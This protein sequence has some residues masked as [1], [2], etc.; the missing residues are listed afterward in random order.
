VIGVLWYCDFE[1]R[2]AYTTRGGVLN[3]DSR[4]SLWDRPKVNECT[5]ASKKSEI[6]RR[7]RQGCAPL[8]LAAPTSHFFFA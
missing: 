8:H 4:V 3:T 5:K 6:V 2:L 1:K 7:N